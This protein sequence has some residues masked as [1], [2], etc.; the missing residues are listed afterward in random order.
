MRKQADAQTA[1]LPTFVAILPNLIESA[2]FAP[3]S[4]LPPG[5]SSRTFATYFPASLACFTA[6]ENLSESPG[7]SSPVIQIAAWPDLPTPLLISA[8]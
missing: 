6:D 1:V 5:E 3:S 4:K 7:T 2:I 8:D